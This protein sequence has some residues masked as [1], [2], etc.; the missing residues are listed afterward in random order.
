[1]ARRNHAAGGSSVLYNIIFTDMIDRLSFPRIIQQ[2]QQAM[3][4]QNKISK[5]HLAAMLV[6]LQTQ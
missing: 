3:F 4:G 6:I 1:M 2:R 5:A